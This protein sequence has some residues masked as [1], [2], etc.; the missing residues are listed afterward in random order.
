MILDR[1]D[2]WW[3]AGTR[4]IE[5]CPDCEEPVYIHYDESNGSTR[6]LHKNKEVEIPSHLWFKNRNK[7][8]KED[9]TPQARDVIH[10]KP[11]KDKD[12]KVKNG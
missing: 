12:L 6:V 9:L 4:D 10:G 2:P 5:R 8:D 7:P 3:T 1:S 11:V